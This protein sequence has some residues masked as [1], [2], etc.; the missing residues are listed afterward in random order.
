VVTAVDTNILL[1]VGFGPTAYSAIA[2][3]ALNTAEMDGDVI[4]STVSYAEIAGE[5]LQAEK[6]SEFLR[7]LSIAITPLD[8][9]TAFLAGQFMREY[10]LR[11]G[12]RTRILA[13]FLVA[14]YAQLHADHL[15]TRDHRFFSDVFPNLKSV[16]PD[17]L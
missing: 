12:T 1:D 16:A 8:A 9:E 14:A 15:L 7:T 3:G 6:L 4:I 13:D 17:D 5:F 10:K 11:G 2:K